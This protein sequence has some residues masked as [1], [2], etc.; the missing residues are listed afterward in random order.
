MDYNLVCLLGNRSPTVLLQTRTLALWIFIFHYSNF[1]FAFP[2]L[3]S[4]MPP[5]S[6]SQLHIFR[7]DGYPFCMD[8]TQIAIFKQPYQMCFCCF[9]QCQNSRA[10]P[11][12]NLP[13]QSLLNLSN[14]S[15]EWQ[16]SNQQVSRCL[17]LADFSQC[18]LSWKIERRKCEMRSETAKTRMD[19]QI[20]FDDQN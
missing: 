18:S 6:P 4:K 10:L 16:P 11:A 17:V 13:W 1:V 5:N 20:T 8:S 3:F 7:H 15:C 19:I 9:L 12:I 2:Y 14:K